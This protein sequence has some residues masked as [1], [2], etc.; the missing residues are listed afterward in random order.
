MVTDC[1]ILEY[2]IEDWKQHFGGTSG[3]ILANAFNLT[4]EKIIEIIKALANSGLVYFQWATIYPVVIRTDGKT[5]DQNKINTI[6]AFP[7][8][9]V[10]AK[11]FEEEGKDYGHFTNRLHKGDSPIGRYYSRQD[12]LDKYLRYPDRYH[13]NSTIIGGYILCTD[14]YYL[15][16]PEDRRDQE[17]VAQIRYGKRQLINGSIAIAAIAKDLSDLPIQEQ[18]Y[19]D[20]YEI[21]AEPDF[22]EDDHEFKQYMR[23]MFG[24][25]WGDYE[26]PLRG[27]CDSVDR[28]NSLTEKLVGAALFKN[29][30]ENPYLQYI[31]IN[32]NEAYQNAH[33]ELYKLLGADSLD[34][35]VLLGLLKER[36]DAKDEELIEKNRKEKG[37]WSLFKTLAMK[38]PDTDFRSFQICFDARV[39]DVHK[40]GT[41]NLPDT[42]LV[43]KFRKDCE[44]ILLSLKKLES[45]LD[46]L[47]TP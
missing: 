46:S 22:V 28:I 9:P 29:I 27:I 25:E 34:K 42:D 43:Q 38:F 3:L 15:S 7:T 12:V 35:N 26:D 45:N 10:L 21:K 16:L 17:T 33:K 37:Q 41:K 2:I 44:E 39:E 5:E 32:T 30:S 47:L 19:W 4:H 24:G 8:R 6:F 36:L 11:I 31:V 14:A 40:V 13:V 23:Q 20:S 18:T 1:E